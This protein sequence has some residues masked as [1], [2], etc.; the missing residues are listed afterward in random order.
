MIGSNT[1]IPVFLSCCIILFLNEGALSNTTSKEAEDIIHST[2][3]LF[4][5]WA[6]IMFDAPF[7]KYF[8]TK[9]LKV[10]CNSDLKKI[11]QV[12]FSSFNTEVLL[13]D[14]K[15]KE[16]LVVYYTVHYSFRN[17]SFIVV[18]VFVNQK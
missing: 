12:Y 1:F 3:A 14:M 18:V 16:Q 11:F 9:N 5:K 6:N 10:S 17:K 7:W 15:L 13:I 2:T 8:N 4:E